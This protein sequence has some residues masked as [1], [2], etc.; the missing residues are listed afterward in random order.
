LGEG[1][2][3][4]L[5][6]PAPW[7]DAAIEK[8]G[9]A[10]WHPFPP[11]T[12]E[13]LA[14]RAEAR[15]SGAKSKRDSKAGGD[16]DAKGPEAVVRRLID[17]YN[18]LVAEK[19]FDD[20]AKLF[21]ERQQETVRQLM[22]VQG[23]LAEKLRVLTSLVAEKAPDEAESLKGFLEAIETQQSAELK[24]ESLSVVSET[25]VVGKAVAP[26]GGVPIPESLLQVRF[27][28]VEGAW[29]IESPAVDAA[30]G[31]VG[32]LP[33]IIQQFDTMIE[34]VRSGSLPAEAVAK[35]LAGMSAMFQFNA[36][37]KPAEPEAKSDAKKPAEADEGG[38]AKEDGE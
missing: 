18:A 14:E 21:V 34:G 5:P 31:T 32:M 29:R 4:L 13:T 22:K 3:L 26:A 25:E 33:V 38:Q 8:G 36:E 11:V 16:P 15:N 30:A 35:Q 37:A 17:D 10:E 7:H 28:L 9:S 2:N 20:Q 27:L 12:P 23:T 1:T 19:K 6:P 24:I